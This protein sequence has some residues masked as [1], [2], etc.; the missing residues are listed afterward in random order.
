MGLRVVRLLFLVGS[1]ACLYAAYD[2]W[3]AG[4]EARAELANVVEPDFWEKM[5]GIFL[6][7][8]E[9]RD[10][11]RLAADLQALHEEYERTMP[12]DTLVWARIANREYAHGRNFAA[13]TRMA[14]STVLEAGCAHA[15]RRI[16]FV[17]RVSIIRWST[18]A[19]RQCADF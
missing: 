4:N 2:E 12:V 10:L 3:E 18:A 9:H 17:N 1:V 16:G 15:P 5:S 6:R 13:I 19:T 14:I 7:A 11:G 8:M